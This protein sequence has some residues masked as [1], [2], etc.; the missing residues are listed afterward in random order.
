MVYAVIFVIEDEHLNHVSCQYAP[1]GNIATFVNDQYPTLAPAS[2]TYM[3]KTHY[4]E[5]V[6]KPRPSPFVNFLRD[7]ASRAVSSHCPWW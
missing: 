6:T 4:T 5:G 7:N 2:N 3:T 1:S